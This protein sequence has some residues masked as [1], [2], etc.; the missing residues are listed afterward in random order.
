MTPIELVIPWPPKQ[1]QGNGTRSR[2]A[3]YRIGKEYRGA[4]YL[5]TMHA[6]PR[7][8]R[9][10]GIG[11]RGDLLVT[12][13]FRQ[14]AKR[15]DGRRNAQRNDDDNIVAAMKY[16][17]DGIADALGVNDRQFRLQRPTHGERVD[18]GAVVVRIEVQP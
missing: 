4:A 1:L 17:L 15:S 14:P 13:E 3:R 11:Y 2:M 8:L 6:M 5:L 16:A 9:G 12:L 7:E 18:G 10:C